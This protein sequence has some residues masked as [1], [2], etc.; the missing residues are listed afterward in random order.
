MTR[1]VL[2]LALVSLAIVATSLAVFGCRPG[3]KSNANGSTVKATAATPTPEESFRQV[4]DTFRRAVDT[5]ASGT[6]TGFVYRDEGG[7]SSLAIHNEVKDHLIPPSKEG[8]P[9]RGIITVSSQFSYSVRIS[10]PSD[11]SDAKSDS[12]GQA[13]QRGSNES[14]QDSG[15]DVLDP[16]LVAAA[17]KSDNPSPVK[18][19]ELIARRSDEEVRTY[20]L[21]YE[22]SRWVLKTKLDPKTEQSI[23]YAFDHALEVQ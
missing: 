8:E 2:P 15:V 1:V 16:D 7:H 9:Y 20:E 10:P 21:A 22:N 14:Q 17:T 19:D 4:A 3:S 12:K 6:Q 13:N 5:D 11:S 23:Q 18:S